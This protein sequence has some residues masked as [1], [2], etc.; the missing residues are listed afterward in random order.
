M[1]FD[2]FD[3]LFN[4]MYNYVNTSSFS[5]NDWT[6]KKYQSPDGKISFTYFSRNNKFEPTLDEIGKLKN[7]L[8]TAV[9]S[10]DFEQAVVLRD[11]IKSL[12]KNK[13]QI[14]YLETKLKECVK[15]QDFEKAIEY[16]D[17]INKLKS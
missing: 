9:E 1:D 15:S 2:S 17:Q 4:K 13:Q 16:R 11:R 12:E 3:D 10:Q 8:D 14:L 7:E 5:G 6:E